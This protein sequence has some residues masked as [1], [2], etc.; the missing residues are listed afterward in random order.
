MTESTESSQV[1]GT[2]LFQNEQDWQGRTVVNLSGYN[3]W[4]VESLGIRKWIQPIPAERMVLFPDI[5]P[6]ETG[7]IVPTGVMADFDMGKIPEWRQF[8]R[9]ADIGCGMQMS[10]LPLKED[11]FMKNRKALDELY[12]RLGREGLLQCFRGNHFINFAKD[13]DTGN[14]HVLVHTGS[15]GDAQKKLSALV[16]HPTQYD[17]EYRRTIESGRDTRDRIMSTIWKVY[18]EGKSFDTVHNTV[19]ID[20]RKGIARVYKGVV[21]VK[22]EDERQVLPS[23]LNGIMVVYRT[24]KKA[25]EIGGTSHGTGRAVSRS[26]IRRSIDEIR[27]QY[28]EK[29]QDGRIDPKQLH[30]MTPTGLRW[31]VTEID[32]AYHSIDRSLDLMEGSG[33]MKHVDQQFLQPVAGIKSGSEE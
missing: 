31:P 24:G 29:E 19:E 2:L 15:Y 30:I 23:S 5:S 32:S 11:D 3:S 4:Q 8:I 27:E 9:G 26:A 16:D 22:K 14:M 7:F 33:L 25:E 10:T 17:A 18:G 13:I 21:A 20:E 6:T 1:A 12:E 28:Q